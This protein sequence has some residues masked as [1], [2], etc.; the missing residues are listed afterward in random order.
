[1][2]ILLIGPSYPFRGGIALFTQRLYQELSLQDEVILINFKRLYP[3][4]LFPGKSQLVPEGALP[5]PPSLPLLHSYNPLSWIRVARRVSREFRADGAIFQWWHPFF[6]P[7][8]RVLSSFLRGLPTIAI[9]HNVIPHEG[10]LATLWGV[11]LGLGAMK[12][13]IVHAQSEEQRIN[14]LFPQKPYRVAFHPIYDHFPIT[15]MTS[16]EARERLGLS[17]RE[18]VLL[19]FGLVRHYKGVDTLLKAMELLTDMADL[20]LL[21]VG[22]VYGKKEDL[23]FGVEQFPSDK[24]R[25]V[26]RFI[27]ERE[28]EVWFKAADVV[29]LP[30]RSA[31]QS[32]VIPLAYHYSK[33]VI[34]TKVGGLGEVVEDKV[35]GLLVPPED[36]PA[37]AWAIRQFFETFSPQHWDEGILK[38]RQA[39]SWARYCEILRDL[40]ESVRS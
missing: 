10:S 19:F 33:P 8:Y 35:S 21:I 36:P 31:T 23:L 38:W 2:R 20:K 26:D 40:V 27:P 17:Q 7:L 4:L 39:L 3:P 11:K 25:I 34:A 22:E 24:V 5:G 1:M 6:A 14:A 15:E 9:C 16:S 32:G 28:A 30:Y 37:L 18:K 29:V 13:F 12:G